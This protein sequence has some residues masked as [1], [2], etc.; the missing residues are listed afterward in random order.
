MINL[1]R[2]VV[3]TLSKRCWAIRQRS[4]S[5][6]VYPTAG[7]IV[8][9][10]EILKA[11]VKD[12]NCFYACKLLWNNGV[13]VQKVSIVRDNL[14][15]ISREV[16]K[17]TRKYNYVFTS[18]GIGPTHDDVT[19]EAIALAFSDKLHYHPTLMDIIKNYFDVKTPNSP[20]F[21]MAYIP[22]KSVLKFGINQDTGQ[23]LPYPC[24][25]MQNVHIFPGS[26][27][28][29]ELSFRALCKELFADNKSF[30][31]TEIYV[32]AREEAFADILSYV[33][34]ECPNV[35]LGSYPERHR[36][37]KA[38][39]TIESENEKNIELAKKLFC[40]RIPSNT[41]VP[42][43]RTPHVACIAKYES[44]I[45]NSERRS[46]YEGCFKKFVDYYQKPEQVCIYLDGSQESVALVHLARVVDDK[47]RLNSR[48][49]LHAVCLD[50]LTL[51]LNHFLRE[52]CQRYN[53][54]LS[55]VE[56]HGDVGLT[57]KNFVATRPE[58][59]VLLL[60]KRSDGN[61]REVYNNFS[62][63]NDANLPLQVY[64][65]LADWTNE[66]FSHFCQSLCIPYHT[67][68]P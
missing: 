29:F 21:K 59:R 32:N 66:D 62:R 67:I 63:L 25:A 48:S 31:A 61:E 30:A 41:I 10:D 37:Y 52:L 11:Q 45:E 13:K 14:M 26:P 15:D 65:P 28:F 51:G 58:C 12:N 46:V 16:Q 22:S 39:V 44:F 68:K 19:Y 49:K 35:S 6:G 8:I 7:I 3:K 38:R 57:I 56:D 9:G 60:G 24:V 42:Y 53:V 36:Y 64:F 18:G 33:A 34:R 20:A 43:D 50:V 40:D 17:F 2:H 1:H 47:L 5:S 27:T 55:V 4:D 54:E 23:T